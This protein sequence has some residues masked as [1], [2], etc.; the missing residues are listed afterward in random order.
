MH[1]TFAQKIKILGSF[2]IVVGILALPF[3][4]PSKDSRPVA[5][6]QHMVVR[7]FTH[8]L[9]IGA[10]TLSVAIADTEVLREQGLSNTSILSADQGMLFVLDTPSIPSFWMKD[11]NYSLDIIW[12]DANKKVI[13]ASENIDPKTFPQTFSPQTPVMYVLE[14]SAGFYKSSY[15][16]VG[17][18]VLF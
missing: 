10:Q 1:R 6:I 4:F 14:V 7:S 13:G 11:M 2:A 18:S 12:I 17:D 16:K 15:I 8:P 3:L 5:P 9:M